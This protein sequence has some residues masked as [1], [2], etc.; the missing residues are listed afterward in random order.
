MVNIKQDFL[1]ETENVKNL[2]VEIK[3]SCDEFDRASHNSSKIADFIKHLLDK[4]SAKIDDH[5][6]R[7]LGIIRRFSKED[8]I[9][10]QKYYQKELVPLFEVSPYNKR[11]YEKPFGYPGDYIMML[12][13]YD[14][15]FE[16]DTTFAKFIHR[17]SMNVPTAKANHNRRHFYKAQI[18][19][20]VS[21]V[22]N[23]NITSIACG[24]AVEIIE[25]LNKNG[26]ANKASFI[27]LDF[28][29]RAL[30]Y[31]KEQINKM[32]Q[33][34][35]L[36]EKM[37]F[38]TADVR[39]LLKLDKVDALFGDQDLI[40]SSGLIDYFS[41][42]ISAKMVELLFKKLKKGGVL[43]VGN[44]SDKDNSMAYTEFLGEWVLNRRSEDEMLK[45]AD[46]ITE[47]KEITIEHE[48]ETGMNIFM[49][50]KKK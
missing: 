29:P 50:I 39:D 7:I 23:P 18:E 2:L 44:V 14:N 16:G 3:G 17:Y 1:K 19:K 35:I 31:V 49:S 8:Y 13:L 36:S 9:V 42:K 41:D 34:K 15:G 47:D 27:C 11:V 40:Y 25:F 48:K 26:N 38:I 22:E 10:H 21:E 20:T 24:P 5:F 30:E 33:G 28:E 43:I 45:L 6:V 4:Y 46:R 32:Q 37:R 12:Y